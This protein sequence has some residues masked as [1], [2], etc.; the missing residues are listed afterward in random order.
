MYLMGGDQEKTLTA[1]SS[2]QSNVPSALVGYQPLHS[3]GLIRYQPFSDT[4]SQM[5]ALA[6][7]MPIVAGMGNAL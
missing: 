3:L 7:A 6:A 1:Q 2:S 5:V 4:I